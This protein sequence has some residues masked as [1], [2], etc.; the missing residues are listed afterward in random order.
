MKL[1]SVSVVIPTHKRP[2]ML[3]RAIESIINQTYKVEEIIV[4]DDAFCDKTKA[5]VEGFDYK[6]LKYF[7]NTNGRGAPSSRNLGAD[8]ATGEFVAFLDDDDEWL[9]EKN[10]LQLQEIAQN[11]LDVCFSQ[12]KVSY[13]NT[14]ISYATKARNVSDPVRE[15]LIE[16]YLGA[17]I[18][19]FIKKDLFIRVGKFDLEFPARQDYDLWI[20]LVTSG[21][22]IGVVEKPL[23]ISYRS[24]EGRS[25]ISSSLKNY[26]MAISMINSKYHNL[27]GEKFVKGD[28]ITRRRRQ[29]DF[30]AA[31]AVS[32]NSRSYAIKYFIK[33]LCLKPR[34]KVVA[35][36]LV[37]AIS[38][39]LM[40][41]IRSHI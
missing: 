10:Q 22:K 40:V 32:I 36:L 21:A 17:T 8:L 41:K 31:Q 24:L 34:I 1:A 12:I 27:L 6:G 13:E 16:N 19:A 23:A 38:P 35:A 4:V 20:R 33:S 18:S 37:S 9:P 5:I 3:K 11:H 2:L 30:M 29:Y 15:I 28:L 14:S 26:E 7:R 39:R 25:R